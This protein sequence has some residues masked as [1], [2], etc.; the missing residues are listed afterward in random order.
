[1]SLKDRLPP[2]NIEAEQGV[3]GSVL[4]DND[5]MHALGVDLRPGDFYRDAHGVIWQAITDLYGAGS[6]IDCLILIDELTRRNQLGT[7]GGDDY[8]AE[9]VNAT[10][11]AANAGYYAGMVREKAIARAVLA[12]ATETIRAVYSNEHTAEQLID[13]AQ[14]GLLEAVDF[15]AAAKGGIKT[16]KDAM[17]RAQNLVDARRLGA[18]VGIPTGLPELDRLCSFSPGSFTVIGGRPGTGKSALAL[19]IALHAATECQI[20]V[21]IA[22]MEM[23]DAE[24]GERAMSILGC[25]GGFQMRHPK[26]LADEEYLRLLGQMARGYE[27]GMHAPIYIDDGSG[28]TS[29]QIVSIARRALVRHQIGLLIVDYLQLC[30]ADDERDNRQ[31]QVSKVSRRLKVLARN[32]EIP[33]I[34]LSQLNRQCESRDDKRPRKSDLR[35]SGSLEQDA[36]NVLL[37]YAPDDRPDEAEII[38]DKSRNGPTGIVRV[39]FRRNLVRFEPWTPPAAQEGTF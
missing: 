9:L 4:L 24:L 23:I 2:S 14:K 10:P 7:I 16:L 8:L 39:N 25:A 37:M 27:R 28:R 34:A 1:M 31:E 35:E 11:H 38:V 19:Q 36:D 18:T 5:A 17:D 13:L 3:I 30:E 29:I 22:S 20:P 12:A 26:D 33:V 15:A 21:L 32:L 6:K